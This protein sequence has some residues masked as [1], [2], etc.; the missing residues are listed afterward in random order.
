[1]ERYENVFIF[2][3][4]LIKHKISILRDKKTGMK[5]FRELIEEITTIMTYESMR[6]V[7]LVPVEVETPLETTIQYRIAE[8][9][10]AIV[11][12]LRAGL[13]MVNGVHRVFPNAKVGHIGMYRDEETLEPHEYYCKLPEG[14]E[15]YNV[16]VQYSYD[17]YPANPNGSPCAVAGI[18]SADGR[19]LAMMPHLERAIFPWQCGDYPA[20]RIADEVTPWIEAFV[21]ARKWIENIKK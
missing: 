19:H 12:I 15:N 5:E 7:E 4:P 20:D 16:V 1:M 9:S 6:D 8:D 2:D 10:I 13:G 14:I 21:N 17:T 18:A 3:H 11:P